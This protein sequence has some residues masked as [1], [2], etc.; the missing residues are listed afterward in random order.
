MGWGWRY[1]R[2]LGGEAGRTLQRVGYR[3]EG[4]GC[5]GEGVDEAVWVTEE[6]NAEQ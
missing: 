4:F 2:C 3:L 5:I 1:S 6:E